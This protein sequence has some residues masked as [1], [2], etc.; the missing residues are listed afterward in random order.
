MAAGRSAGRSGPRWRPVS[1][2]AIAERLVLSVR[3]VD[4]APGS[5]YAELGVRGRA[6]LRAVF[7]PSRT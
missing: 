6:E 1:A 5:A 4:N 2:R 7:A 3:T